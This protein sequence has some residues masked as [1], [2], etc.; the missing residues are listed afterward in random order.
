MSATPLTTLAKVKQ[1]L[2]VKNVDDDALIT[3]LILSASEVI[4]NYLNRSILTAA[5][6]EKYAG[7]GN[8]TLMLRQGPVTAVASLSVGGQVVLPSSNGITTGFVF[9]ETSI[10]YVGGS[11]PRGFDNVVVT[12]TAGYAAI[13]EAV[14]EACIDWVSLRYRERSRIGKNSDSLAQGGSTTYSKEPLSPK[15]LSLLAFYRRVIPV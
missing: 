13:P 12:Y 4:Y 8:P 15:T 9:N 10:H 3:R 2:D 5:Y 6:T 11:F 1:F 14:E 7:Y